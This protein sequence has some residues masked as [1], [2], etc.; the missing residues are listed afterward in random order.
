MKQSIASIKLS[1]LELNTTA[2]T[3]KAVRIL[4]LRMAATLNASE[5]YQAVAL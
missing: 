4:Q 5:I 2:Y 1:K 3:V